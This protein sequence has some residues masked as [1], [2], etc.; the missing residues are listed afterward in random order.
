MSGETKGPPKS[1]TKSGG[2]DPVVVCLHTWREVQELPQDGV[3]GV[4]KALS[5]V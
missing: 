2:C 5:D 1:E 4:T 3:A